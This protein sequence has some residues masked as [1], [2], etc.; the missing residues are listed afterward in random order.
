MG[1]H[2]E[3]I[4]RFPKYSPF[5]VIELN[6]AKITPEACREILNE[7]VGTNSTIYIERGVRT[8]DIIGPQTLFDAK[9]LDPEN[10]QKFLEAKASCIE[11]ARRVFIKTSTLRFYRN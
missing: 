6:P 8:T 3:R 11:K 7:R 4:L 9:K 10:Q 2:K 5:E 1:R